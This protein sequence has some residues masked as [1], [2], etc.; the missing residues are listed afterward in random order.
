MMTGKPETA[1]PANPVRGEITVE[2]GQPAVSYV[3]RPSYEA[4]VAIETATDKGLMRLFRDANDGNLSLSNCAEIVS[5]CVRAQGRAKN[6]PFLAGV[7]ADRIGQL[8]MES[9][10]GLAGVLGRITVLIGFAMCGD[11]DASGE[12]KAAKAGAPTPPASD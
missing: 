11:Y 9:D 8:I 6:D 10:L 7:Q 3:L 2:L 5:Q 4:I 1:E 12:L